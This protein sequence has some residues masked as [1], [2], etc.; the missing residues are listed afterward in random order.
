V[1][2]VEGYLGAM[3]GDLVDGKVSRHVVVVVRFN[4]YIQVG[5]ERRVRS[6]RKGKERKGKE[7]EKEQW[8]REE[9]KR[10]VREGKK[11]KEGERRDLKEFSSR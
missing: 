8:A 9:M 6:E 7:E 5:V 4:V 11:K 10:E 3:A 1:V 2:V